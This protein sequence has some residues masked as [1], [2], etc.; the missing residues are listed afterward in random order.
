MRPVLKEEDRR[1]LLTRRGRVASAE[2]TREPGVRHPDTSSRRS[3]L[4]RWN[5]HS[6]HLVTLFQK[7]FRQ[8]GAVLAGNACWTRRFALAESR[9]SSIMHE[10]ITT[11]RSGVRSC[12]GGTLLA[13]GGGR[14]ARCCPPSGGRRRSRLQRECGQY[15]DQTTCLRCVKIRARRRGEGGAERRARVTRFGCA[16]G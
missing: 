15:E 1:I 6:V 12:A 7:E 4:V 8:V 13:R 3:L 16:V 5:L 11:H 9:S 2:D 14:C 10:G